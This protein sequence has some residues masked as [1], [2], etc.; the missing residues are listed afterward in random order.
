LVRFAGGMIKESACGSLKSC[1]SL[2]LSSGC[3]RF[4]RGFPS[5]GLPSRLCGQ[6]LCIKIWLKW[7]KSM[8]HCLWGLARSVWTKNYVTLA[9]SSKFDWSVWTKNLCNIACEP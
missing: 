5:R 6:R 3:T 7:Q 2:L 8:L 1:S 9:A 4:T